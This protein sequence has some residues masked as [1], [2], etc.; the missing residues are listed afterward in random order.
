M[1]SYSTDQIAVISYQCN[2]GSA[3]PG[4]VNRFNYYDPEGYP[5]VTADGLTDIWPCALS[6]LVSNYNA[7][8][9]VASPLQITV[10]EDAEGVFTAH[11]TASSSVTGRFMMVA[12]EDLTYSSR[13]YQR[14]ARQLLTPYN[15]EAFSLS[16]GQSVEI[17]KTFTVSGDWNYANMGVVAWVYENSD[18][19]WATHVSYQA[20]T[21]F[22]SGSPATP[23][24]SRTP[25]TTPTLR[26]TASPTP[27][28]TPTEPPAT[29]TPEPPTP[30]SVPPTPSEVPPT[31][32]PTCGELGVRLWMPSEYY[33]TGDECECRVYLCNPGT[34]L[35]TGVPLFVL[36]DVYGM[37]YFAPNFTEYD[38]YMIDLAPGETAVQVLDRFQWPEGVGSMAGVRWIAAMT[39]VNVTHLVGASSIWEFGWGD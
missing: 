24:P 15:G 8:T 32:T 13:R 1:N 19:N 18:M 29:F 31:F 10:T 16:S 30:T 5:T 37:Y 20:A 7:R 14:F 25:T 6:D 11:I 3:V 12:F 17:T 22:A 27:S 34:S 36:L 2:G 26:P 35:Y 33:H 39:D 9:G 23:S 38:Y 21:G 28:R 4:G